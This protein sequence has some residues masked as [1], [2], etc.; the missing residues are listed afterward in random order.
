MNWSMAMVMKSKYM[1]S[2]MGR[3]PAMAAPTAAPAMAAS[4]GEA[5]PKAFGE[6]LNE[7]GAGTL[8]R[9][10]GATHIEVRFEPGRNTG[11]WQ[12]VQ[13]GLVVSYPV[14]L[15]GPLRVASGGGG[16]L[17]QMLRERFEGAPLPPAEG[18][19][20]ESNRAR[21]Q[22]CRFLLNAG[23]P[24]SKT[25]YFGFTSPDRRGLLEAAWMRTV[26]A[27]RNLLGRRQ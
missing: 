25:L 5:L 15:A 14:S 23:I 9:R 20:H 27:G 1:I 8:M 21:N 2:A 19:M 18:L 3:M 10:R 6:E 11:Y 4:L 17:A 12:R 16:P 22:H 26:I 13:G 7:L 24:G